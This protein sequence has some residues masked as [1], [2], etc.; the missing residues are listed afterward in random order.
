[1]NLNIS[2]D[3]SEIQN[4]LT[5]ETPR[6][7]RNA[8][9]SAVKTTTTWAKKELDTRMAAESDMPIGVF[10]KHR[11]FKATPM[12]EL[13]I[14]EG[15]VWIGYRRIRAKFAGAI[16]QGIGYLMAGRYHFPNGFMYRD[17]VFSRR[18]R[19]KLR[20]TKGRYVG[21]QRERIYKEFIALPKTPEITT[22]VSEQ[23]QAMLIQKFIAK[24]E[25]NTNG[26][27]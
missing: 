1:M 23:A 11:I 2:I 4:A 12:G 20:M 17:N 3:D 26:V 24:F 10:K 25:S 15:K 21:K 5:V 8:L 16:D 13:G 9:R 22:K 6:K 7:V 19:Q 14:E 18:N 27:D